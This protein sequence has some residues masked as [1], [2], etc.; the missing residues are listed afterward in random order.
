MATRQ[1]N[2][3]QRTKNDA[4][5]CAPTQSLREDTEAR[6]EHSASY[7]QDNDMDNEPVLMGYFR[8]CRREALGP[9]G[10]TA[11]IFGVFVFALMLLLP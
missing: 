6:D 3:E 4:G 9:V 1:E 8:Y 10:L 2:E 5:S 11:V 7:D